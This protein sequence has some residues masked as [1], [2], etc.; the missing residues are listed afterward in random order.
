MQD[1]NLLKEMERIDKPVI[2]KRGIR[3]LDTSCCNVM[4]VTCI[5]VLNRETHL[6]VIIDP[7]HAGG[8]T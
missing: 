6:L 1:F 4:N 7:S 2:L 8:K 5:P 3:T